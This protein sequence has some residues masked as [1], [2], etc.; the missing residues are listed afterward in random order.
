MFV[1]TGG[2][3]GP[4]KFDNSKESNLILEFKIKFRTVSASEPFLE[5]RLP[6]MLRASFKSLGKVSNTFLKCTSISI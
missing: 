3:I 1:A 4:R 6:L 2:T 5:E